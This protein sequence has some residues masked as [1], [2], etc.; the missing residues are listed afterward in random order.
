MQST[1]QSDISSHLIL[2]IILTDGCSYYLSFT[3]EANE[4]QKLFY[5]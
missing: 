1:L 4:A 3:D 5:V 2:T